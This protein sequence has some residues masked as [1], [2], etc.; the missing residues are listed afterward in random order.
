[1]AQGTITYSS[2]TI[3][4][5]GSGNVTAFIR[6]LR[7]LLKAYAGNAWVDGD[8]VNDVVGSVDYVMRSVGDPALG[9]GDNKGDTEIWVRIRQP[10]VTQV[11]VHA[12][13]DW[14]AT[15]HT[16]SREVYTSAF[17]MSDSAAID[18]WI[19]YNQYKC[20]FFALQNSNWFAIVFGSVERTFPT[21]LNGIA[22]LSQATAGTGAI[23]LNVD[24]DI[25][26]H[27]RAGQKVWLV[28][29]TPVGQSL[30][31]AHTEIVTVTSVGTSTIG[32]S[33]VA[34]TPYEIGSLVGLDPCP[35]YMYQGATLSASSNFRA[36]S[37]RDSTYT[38]VT[39]QTL[40]LDPAVTMTLANERPDV[41]G[42]YAGY[43]AA[44]RQST[45]GAGYAA[46]YRGNFG[47]HMLWFACGTQVDLDLHR[48]NYDDAKKYK[49]FY[50]LGGGASS[51]LP[52]IGPGA[53]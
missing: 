49:V 21:E 37:H 17:T 38:G 48:L 1:M 9:S 20:V 47:N 16:G 39:S 45:S 35:T 41:D 42:F 36:V 44:F 7:T 22:R 52:A 34:N 12:Y 8:V 40:V 11:Q 33:G 50:T 15:S 18:W 14:S 24:R 5:A 6:Q 51:W 25:S 30:K 26:T 29:H 31:T 10:S 3:A 27:L 46:G 13:Q 43:E 2:G 53:S 28:N 4:A 32:V 19:V 23:T